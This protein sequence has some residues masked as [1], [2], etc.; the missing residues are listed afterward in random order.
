[1]ARTGQTCDQR[2]VKAIIA[3]K[4][5]QFLGCGIGPWDLD[6]EKYDEWK[7]V[8]CSIVDELPDYQT[9]AVTQSKKQDEWRARQ[10]YRNKSGLLQRH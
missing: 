7:E 3:K 9:L 5:N 8:I 6:D 2:L 1:M 4:I 10:G